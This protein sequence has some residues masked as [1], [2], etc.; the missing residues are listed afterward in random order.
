MLLLFQLS[1]LN[2]QICQWCSEWFF[3]HLKMCTMRMSLHRT[4]WSCLNCSRLAGWGSNQ[5]GRL[6]QKSNKWPESQVLCLTEQ[7]F[8]KSYTWIWGNQEPLL[9]SSQNEGSFLVNQY[10]VLGALRKVPGSDWPQQ[11]TAELQTLPYKGN[12]RWSMFPET[13]S[14]SI[15]ETSSHVS[16]WKQSYVCV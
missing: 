12:M 11:V 4:H 7:M 3:I 15:H 5:L 8:P 6:F 14:W 10:V 9:W 16:A 1:K 13:K 2:N